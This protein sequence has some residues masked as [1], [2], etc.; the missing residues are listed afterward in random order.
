M[1]IFFFPAEGSGATNGEMVGKKLANLGDE[2]DALCSDQFADCVSLY[3][4]PQEAL[5]S[6]NMVLTN[7]FE[8]EEGGTR[9]FTTEHKTVYCLYCFP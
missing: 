7:V 9:E 5:R 6:F 4:N 8:W 2:I 3:E 1:F